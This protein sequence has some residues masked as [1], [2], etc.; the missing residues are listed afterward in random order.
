MD[1]KKKKILI[2]S[3]LGV[4]VVVLITVLI[5]LLTGNQDNTNNNSNNQNVEIIYWGL[6]EP[7][8]VMHPL[9]EKYEAEHPGVKIVY[10]QQTFKNYESRLY[11]RLEQSTNSSEPAP[12]IFRIN[13][14]WLPKYKKYLSS[15]PGDIMS[16]DKYKEEFY[17]TALEDFTGVDGKIY[18]IPWGIDGLALF[19]NKQLLTKAG[20]TEPPKDWDS[21]TEAAQ[22]LT[23]TDSSG[24]ITQA[25]LAIGT[26]KNIL[27]SADI[28]T[29]LMLQNNAQLID[30]TKTEA[31]LTS[32]RAVSA[33]ERYTDFAKA[34]NPTWASYLADDLTMF[35]RGQLAMMFAPSWRAFDIINAAPQIEFGITTLPQ[36]PNND[37]VYYAMYWG[38]AVSSTCENPEVAWDFINFLSEPEQQ[39]RLFS[40]ASQVR[41]FGEPYSRVS[42]N[43]ELLQNPYTKAFGQM[44]PQMKSWQMGEQTFVDNLFKEAITEVAENNKSASTVLKN[45]ETDIND[46]LADTNK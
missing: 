3:S 36:L 44:A 9:I 38:D 40:N 14:T 33:L 11:T 7:D 1:S 22:K 21:L 31:N 26:S 23:T 24:K 45:I 46:Q 12:D 16:K 6:W 20:Y 8:E 35:F 42:M 2:F 13:N 28:L 17:P 4:I 18:A 10:T 32:D 41:A 15:L 27:H 5:L 39:R 30:S 29:F 25:G 37:P 34:Q 19:Y 43:E